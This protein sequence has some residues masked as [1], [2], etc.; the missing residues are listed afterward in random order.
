VNVLAAA[1]RGAAAASDPRRV[2]S[3]RPGR[4]ASEG[5]GARGLLA[6]GEERLNLPT[7]TRLVPHSG[8]PGSSSHGGEGMRGR[9][10]P[11]S[12][13]TLAGRLGGGARQKCAERM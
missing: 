12:S 3:R 13:R 6:A 4:F 11:P 1:P 5:D 2:A 7:T 10:E 9:D 8:H